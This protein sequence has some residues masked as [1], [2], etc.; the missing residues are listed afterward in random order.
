MWLAR[1]KGVGGAPSP[2]L[3][4][5]LVGLVFW[6]VSVFGVVWEGL[7]VGVGGPRREFRG[8]F[9]L[10]C[11]RWFSWNGPGIR[12]EPGGGIGGVPGV[13]SGFGGLFGHGRVTPP[14]FSG[15]SARARRTP[16]RLKAD[17]TPSSTAGVKGFF[18]DPT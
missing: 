12:L 2:L 3:G 16:S 6:F 11:F 17:P 1:D 18:R 9:G 8:R 5:G 13:F 10:V 15:G 14:L 4:H 7:L